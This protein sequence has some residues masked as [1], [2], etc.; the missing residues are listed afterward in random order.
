[1]VID[2]DIRENKRHLVAKA[3][4]TFKTKKEAAEALGISARHLA[5]LAPQVEELVQEYKTSLEENQQEG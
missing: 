5:T 2:Y 4:A 1:M 3:L